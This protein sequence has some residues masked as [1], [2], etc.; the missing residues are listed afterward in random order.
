ME[1]SL[2]SDGFWKPSSITMTLA[3]RAFACCAPGTRAAATIVGAT[4]ASSSGS[5]PTC[6]AVCAASTAPAR[7][8]PAVAGDRN[9]AVPGRDPQRAIAMA[10]GVLR[11]RL[12]RMPTQIHRNAEWA[13]PLRQP[14]RRNRSVI[15]A[16]GESSARLVPD[17]PTKS[18]ARA[19]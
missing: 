19:I 16:S 15:A 5:S 18:P 4:R 3:P 17:C 7:Q 2:A 1:R 12:R 10:V 8:Q 13:R 11:R 9:K 6:A 14:A